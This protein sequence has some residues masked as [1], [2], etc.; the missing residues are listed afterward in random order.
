MHLA[1]LAPRNVTA[2]DQDSQD[3]S[4][5]TAHLILAA[6]MD[7]FTNATWVPE[8]LVIMAL[9]NLVTS[10]VSFNAKRMAQL[11][12]SSRFRP[13]GHIVLIR[14]G[15]LNLKLSVW[16]TRHSKIA[17]IVCLIL[18]SLSGTTTSQR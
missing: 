10:A 13:V 18:Y 16:D 14:N 5:V 3:C 11:C 9:E 17:R 4:A 6:S 1:R 2:S 15:L 12:V 8:R 7:M